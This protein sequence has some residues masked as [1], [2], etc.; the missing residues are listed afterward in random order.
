MARLNLV[1]FFGVFV[2]KTRSKK[3][4]ARPLPFSFDSSPIKCYAKS[5]ERHTQR[6]TQEYDIYTKT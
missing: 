3:V 5:I 2:Y 1:I 4:E 6:Y